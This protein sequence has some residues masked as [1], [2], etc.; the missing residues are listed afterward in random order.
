MVAFSGDLEKQEN[1]KEEHAED[2]EEAEGLVVGDGAA[3]DGLTGV[4][5]EE[6][7]VEAV[8]HAEEEAEDAEGEGG[9]HGDQEDAGG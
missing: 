3:E 4:M 6:G 1:K 9:G 2:S 8:E 5:V 7:F